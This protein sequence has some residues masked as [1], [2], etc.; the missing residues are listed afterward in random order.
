M[1]GMHINCGLAGADWIRLA[2]PV[3][4]KVKSKIHKLTGSI[5][6]C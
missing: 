1:V 3:C 2:D 6:P 5:L 4:D